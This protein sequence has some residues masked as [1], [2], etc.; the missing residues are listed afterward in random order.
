MLNKI[1]SGLGIALSCLYADDLPISAQD[2]ASVLAAA[3]VLKF[4]ELVKR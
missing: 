4:D 3:S 1:F 2:L